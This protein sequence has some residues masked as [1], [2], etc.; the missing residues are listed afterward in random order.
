MRRK[1]AA[2]TTAGAAVAAAGA[3]APAVSAAA[4]AVGAA[5]TAAAVAAAAGGDNLIARLFASSNVIITVGSVLG[6]LRLEHNPSVHYK[7]DL[8]W[9]RLR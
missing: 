5:V 8:P 4:P 1:G 2:V 3:A 6:R 9:Q 7:S